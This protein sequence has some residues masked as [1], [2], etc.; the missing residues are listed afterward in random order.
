M[1][2]YALAVAGGSVSYV[3]FLTLLLPVR[4]AEFSAGRTI[5]YLAYIAFFGAI[6]ASLANIGFGWASDRTGRREPW[7][8]GG[9]LLS[10]LLLVSVRATD[11]PLEL[12]VTIVLWQIAINMMLGPLAA[13]AGDV[14]P[15]EQKGLLGG[16]LAFAPALGA[17]SGALVTFPG[18][19]GQ[20]DRLL[21]VAGLVACMVLPVI[22]FGKPRPMPH[23]VAPSEVSGKRPRSFGRGAVRKMWLARLLVQITEAALFAYLLVWIMGIDEAF[24]DNDTARLFAVVLGLSVPLAL[25]AGRWSDRHDRPI[26]L[27]AVGAGVGGCGLLLMALSSSLAGAI[28]GYMVFGL[29]TGV[30]LALH[31]SQTLRVLPRPETR[32]RDLGLFNL[33]N[34][35]P[36]L[37][38]PWIAIALVPSFGFGALFFV[39]AAL[40]AMAMALLLTISRTR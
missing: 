31:S 18:L 2:L 6:A 36:S 16:L 32:G 30:F 37:I 8:V 7:I 26:I 10:C 40:A 29:S 15:D 38:M 24:T 33:T 11:G 12:I 4:V 19:A 3:P 39:L 23:L 9:L 13:W 22:V 21:L 28:A 27:L 17:A 5:D 35:V 34:T 1:W 20:D 14:I 25:L